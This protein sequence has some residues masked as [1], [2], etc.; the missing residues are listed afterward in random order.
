MVFTR[1]SNLR[2]HQKAKHKET[3]DTGDQRIAGT[4]FV[5]SVAYTSEGG[6]N[7]EQ[8]DCSYQVDKIN[9]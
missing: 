4:E 1:A 3:S 7:S 9:N 8:S 6:V 2:N 5:D